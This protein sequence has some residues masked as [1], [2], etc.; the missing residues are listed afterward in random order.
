MVL[1]VPVALWCSG[2]HYCTTSFNKVWTQVLRRF[3][4]CSQHVGDLRWWGSLTMVPRLEIRLSAFRQS[5]IP[6]KQ[7]FIIITIIIIIITIIIITNVKNFTPQN[8]F[9]EDLRFQK[10]V[11]FLTP[12]NY[13]VKNEKLLLV[14]KNYHFKNRCP[15]KISRYSPD[16]HGVK[17]G[18]L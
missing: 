11:I 18:H 16:P 12:G 5:T 3:K 7:F 4:S 2:Y 15:Q 13:S 17:T 1:C 8:K 10:L 9:L 14:I 6:Q